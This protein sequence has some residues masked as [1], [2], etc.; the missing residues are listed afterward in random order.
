MSKLIQERAT[1]RPH[2]EVA[3]GKGKA[4]ETQKV[5]KADRKKD[6][7]S[8]DR[9]ISSAKA[10]KST[11]D[12]SCIIYLG[13]IPHGFFE[14]E[15]RK[16]FSQFGLVKRLKL[17]RSPKTNASKGYAFIEFETSDVAKV[18]SEAMSGYFIMDK[19]LVS[20]VVPTS[21]HHDGM[22]KSSRKRGLNS[23]EEEEAGNEACARS[24]EPVSSIKIIDDESYEKALNQHVMRLRSKEKR[25]KAAGID[26][27]IPIPS[28]V[29]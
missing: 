4:T 15:M 22:F 26:F 24:T 20:H 6:A 21:K 28:S 10:S 1:S 14:V 27:K 8:I 18:V 19:Q 11:S 2:D 16:F 12:E 25:L 5:K 9:N 3:L 23:D 13:H 17:F 29:I 7:K